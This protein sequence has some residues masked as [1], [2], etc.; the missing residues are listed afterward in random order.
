MVNIIQRV[1]NDP[2]KLQTVHSLVKK[3][4]AIKEGCFKF[5]EPMPCPKYKPARPLKPVQKRPLPSCP[6]KEKCNKWIT[7]PVEATSLMGNGKLLGNRI[8]N[9]IV[10]R[11]NVEIRKPRVSQS[12]VSYKTSF[13]QFSNP[14]PKETKVKEPKE[15]DIPENKPMKLKFSFWQKES[16]THSLS[17]KVRSEKNQE[18]LDSLKKAEER[19]EEMF[20]KHMFPIKDRD[21]LFTKRPTTL[22]SNFWTNTS[23]TVFLN[24]KNAKTTGFDSYATK[25]FTTAKRFPSKEESS[26]M[27]LKPQFR[28][29]AKTVY[30]NKI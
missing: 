17:D 15:L 27:T 22:T 7:P 4:P 16:K 11:S 8:L 18:V 20:V 24:S 3:K 19:N 30:V 26:P 28:R 25:D 6:P 23:K 10:Q 14:I 29:D 21:F 2:S 1:V 5:P 9:D 12:L 13:R